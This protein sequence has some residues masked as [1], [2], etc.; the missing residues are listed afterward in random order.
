MRTDTSKNIDSQIEE[1]ERKIKLLESS[2]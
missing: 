2:K 1:L